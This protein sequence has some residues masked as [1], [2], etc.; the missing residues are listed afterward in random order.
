MIGR[1]YSYGANRSLSSH[2]WLTDTFFTPKFL[3]FHHFPD[4][5]VLQNIYLLQILQCY[6][7]IRSNVFLKS[8][9]NRLWIKISLSSWRANISKGGKN[10]WVPKYIQPIRQTSKMKYSDSFYF[11]MYQMY[12]VLKLFDDKI[13]IKRPPCLRDRCSDIIFNIWL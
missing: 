11:P 12:D 3:W 1:I 8:N 2:I 9:E 7:F 5:I 6:R 10:R 4:Y 13:K